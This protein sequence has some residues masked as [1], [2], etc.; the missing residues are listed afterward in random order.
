[1]QLFPAIKHCTKN[2][3]SNSLVGQIQVISILQTEGEV[4]RKRSILKVPPWSGKYG[5]IIV[6]FNVLQL[7]CIKEIKG[8]NT[9]AFKSSGFVY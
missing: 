8:K 4:K 7:L 6:I 1:M 5:I 9:G 2:N 3:P